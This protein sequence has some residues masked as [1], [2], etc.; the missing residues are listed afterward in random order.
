MCPR[1]EEEEKRERATYIYV[2]ADVFLCEIAAI[3]L[4]IFHEWV[5]PYRRGFYCDD[6]SIRY[7]FRQSTISRQMLVVVGL[8]IPTLL[9]GG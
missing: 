9:V 8:I 3:P 2:S 6:E 5:K 1:G 7:P 4:L